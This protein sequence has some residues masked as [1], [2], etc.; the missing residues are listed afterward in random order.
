[1]FCIPLRK[2]KGFFHAVFSSAKNLFSLAKSRE[3]RNFFMKKQTRSTRFDHIRRITA[4]AMMVAMYFV[5]DG[6]SIK[7]ND[8]MKI[9]F[10]SIAIII[11]AMLYGTLDACIV[12]GLGEFL[13]QIKFISPF[14]PLFVL[15]QIVRALI[16]GAFCSLVFRRGAYIERK[17]VWLYSMCII[18]GL[19]TS[20]LNTIVVY[21]YLMYMGGFG[22]TFIVPPA[23]W[24]TRIPTFTSTFITAIVLATISIPLVTALRRAGIG[25]KILKEEVSEK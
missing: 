4:D 19:V 2:V 24:A 23:Y 14:L 17:P 15:V 22:I 13:I 20:T 7:L 11:C 16:M 5:L 6:I 10:I 12:A 8:F 1:V 21:A 9:T 18:S 25:R 3:R